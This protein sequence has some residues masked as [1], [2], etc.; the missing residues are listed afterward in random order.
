MDARARALATLSQFL[1]A[2]SSLGD[3]LHEVTAITQA[4]VPTAEMAGITMLSESGKPATTV[5]TDALAPE[6]DK[7]Q[8]D[9]NRGPCLDAWRT[10]QVVRIDRIGDARG[11]YPEFATA[12]KEHG[13]LSTLSLPL[14]AADRGLGALNLYARTVCGFT[15]DDESLGTELAATAAVVLANASAYWEAFTLS[16][17]LTEAMESRAVIEQAKG[18]LMARAS[19]LTA[20]EAFGLL[21]RASQR[22]NRKLRDIAQRIVERKGPQ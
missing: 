18:M 2:G 9:S 11:T 16:E 6:I 7:S 10:K 13:V 5:F 17:Q 22:E 15:R 19:T 12:C 1:V 21:V 4:A 14:V 3:A 20:D 8:Y